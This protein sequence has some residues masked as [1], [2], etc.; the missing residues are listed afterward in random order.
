MDNLSMEVKNAPAL[1]G[2]GGRVPPPPP[3]PTFQYIALP[4]LLCKTKGSPSPLW[5]YF[6]HLW[7]TC[8]SIVPQALQ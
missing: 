4:L 7:L 8:G 3:P 1:R 6:L 2:N 5:I